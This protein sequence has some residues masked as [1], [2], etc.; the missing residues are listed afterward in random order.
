V[1]GDGKP[2]VTYVGNLFDLV[3]EGP[4][5]SV[6]TYQV[7]D[8]VWV[9]GAH[10]QSGRRWLGHIESRHS[11]R[12]PVGRRWLVKVRRPSGWTSG[13]VHMYIERKLTPD[14]FAEHRRLGLI[15]QPGERL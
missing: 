3:G 15:P 14:E 12:S 1:S 13:A 5:A 10:D 9:N 7:G 6:R 8:F 2:T 4:C 11:V